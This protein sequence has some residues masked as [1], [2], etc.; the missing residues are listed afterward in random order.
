MS[1]YDGLARYLSERDED[2][3][4]L[5]F[6]EVAALVQGGLPQSAYDY[7][8]WW[9]NRYDGKDAQNVGWQSAGWESADVD[10][11]RK[12]V[13]FNRTFKT[14][15]SFGADYVKPLSIEQA[16]AGLAAAFHVSADKI[17]ITIRG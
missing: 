12:K 17:E 6:D 2:S 7:R 5:S 1:K 11:K 13:T 10:M 15:S 14:R 4:S 3:V 9:A 8:P 16:K